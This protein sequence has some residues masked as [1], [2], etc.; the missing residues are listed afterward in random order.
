MV[1]ILSWQKDQTAV[2][3]HDVNN[4]PLGSIVYRKDGCSISEK[5]AY[6]VCLLVLQGLKDKRFDLFLVTDYQFKCGYVKLRRGN[7]TN[8]SETKYF[9]IE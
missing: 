5:K 2:T 6:L 8:S 4:E 9:T 3:K 7:G 1:K